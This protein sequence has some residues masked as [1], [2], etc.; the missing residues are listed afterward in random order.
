VKRPPLS[1]FDRYLNLARAAGVR[2]ARI[3]PARAV[4]ASDWVRFKCQY[5]CSGFGKRLCCPPLSPTPEQTR[6]M[7]TDYRWALIY[8]YP[9][10]LETRIRRHRKMQRLVVALERAM[11]LDGF[12]KAF[13]L[14][15]GPCRLC[16]SCAPDRPCR[17][18]DLARPAMEACGIDV[19]AT[20]RNAGIELKVVTRLDA[21]SKHVN[22]ILI[23]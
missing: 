11:F 1:R 8:T 12:Y 10:T 2:D 4:V 21:E 19:Y 9:A 20:C 18:P 5:G 23:E 16:A 13:G 15:A 22:L 7:L 17:F 3:I 6:R 14:C